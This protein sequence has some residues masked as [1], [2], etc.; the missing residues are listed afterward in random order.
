MS[1]FHSNKF[2]NLFILQLPYTSLQSTGNKVIYL[3]LNLFGL[4]NGEYI[5][6]SEMWCWYLNDNLGR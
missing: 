1:L 4:T 3:S 2:V 5:Y 6:V